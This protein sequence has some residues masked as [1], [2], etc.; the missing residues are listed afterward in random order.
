MYFFTDHHLIFMKI[1]F[2]MIVGQTEMNGFVVTGPFAF[3]R[4][5][6]GRPY[7]QRNLGREG[8]LF[9]EAQINSVIQ[10]TNI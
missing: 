10:Q 9:S 3:W 4:T 2:Y 8:Q 7:I 5:L 1:K 6:E